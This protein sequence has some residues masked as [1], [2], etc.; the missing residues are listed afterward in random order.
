SPASISAWLNAPMSAK[1]SAG[2]MPP[3]SES[4]VALT[5]TMT[6]IVV[7]SDSSRTPLDV[8]ELR[9]PVHPSPF[10]GRVQH[11]P[12]RRGI[13]RAARVLAGVGGLVRHLSRPE[14]ADRSV[15]AGEHVEGRDFGAVGQDAEII[16]RIGAVEIAEEAKVAPAALLFPGDQAL[17]RRARDDGK[18]EPLAD[19]GR[20]ARPRAQCIGAH[21]AR[22]RALGPEHVAVDGERL[23]VAEQSG[24]IGRAVFAFKAVVAD[25]RA[26]GRQRPPLSRN[27]LDMTAQLDL[28]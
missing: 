23:L 1:S 4:F 5:I 20:I 16:A 22:T 25:N 12:Q 7:L 13:G 11:H 8:V 18:R 24:E 17:D 9:I 14:M 28:R 21:R 19:V 2:G 6:R 26:A 10:R 27:A 3:T 15:P